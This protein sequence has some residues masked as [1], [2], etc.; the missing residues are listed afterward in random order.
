MYIINVYTN[1][2]VADHTGAEVLAEPFRH[3]SLPRFLDDAGYIENLITELQSLDMQEKN[4]DLYKFK[5]VEFITLSTSWRI[6]G[7][8]GYYALYTQHTNLN[9]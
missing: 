1:D 7:G 2:I 9:R 4:N 3:V 6:G 5:Q 8:G